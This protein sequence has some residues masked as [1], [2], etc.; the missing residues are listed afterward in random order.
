MTKPCHDVFFIH[1]L[2]VRSRFSLS[3]PPGHI[4]VLSAS[5]KLLF[6]DD[7]E[8]SVAVINRSGEPLA[9]GIS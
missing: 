9:G 2:F 6:Y 5:E 8:V 4:A 3:C 1:F 7:H